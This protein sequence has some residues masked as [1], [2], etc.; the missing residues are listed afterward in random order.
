MKKEQLS[1]I[2]TILEKGIETAELNKVN[3]VLTTDKVFIYKK[4]GYVPYKQAVF[5]EVKDRVNYDLVRTKVMEEMQKL[6]Q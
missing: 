4:T 6:Y 3:T 1:G 5:T 2:D